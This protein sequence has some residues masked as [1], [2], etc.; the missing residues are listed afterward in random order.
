[1]SNSQSTSGGKIFG[2]L[3]LAMLIGFPMV[4][5]LWETLNTLMAG[6]VHRERLLIS[7]PVL[8]VFALYLRLLARLLH[9]LEAR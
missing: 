5:Y 8:L 7:L 3:L 4:A 6:E 1:M 9:R 2:M